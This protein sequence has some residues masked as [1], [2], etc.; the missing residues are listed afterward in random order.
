MVTTKKKKKKTW[1]IVLI[2][3]LAIIITLVVI[4]SKANVSNIA[5]SKATAVTGDIEKYITAS[6]NIQAKNMQSSIALNGGDVENLNYEEGDFVKKDSTILTID[7]TNYKAPFD[8]TITFLNVKKG[9]TVDMKDVLFTV[10]DMSKYD[11]IVPINEAKYHDLAINQKATL[12][13]TAAPKHSFYATVTKIASDGI[14]SS[15]ATLFNTYLD[16]DMTDEAISLLR[17]NMTCELK[18]L[19]NS[20]K[21]VTVLPVKAITYDGDMPYVLVKD[22]ESYLRKEVSLGASDGVIVEIQDGISVGEDVYY[23]SDNT[24]RMQQMMERFN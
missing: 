18:I 19:T 11:L 4:S 21:N 23:T 5:Y 15:G 1:L 2:I 10:T 24:S 7:F 16:I 6:S 9:D 3:V 17:H 12:T 20:T 22:G 8:G 13:F 14:K